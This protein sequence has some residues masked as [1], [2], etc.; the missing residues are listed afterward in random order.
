MYVIVLVLGHWSGARERPQ[1]LVSD[2][3]G[4][5]HKVGPRNH[6]RYQLNTQI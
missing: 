6:I 5:P 3:N 2:N 4:G 1:T